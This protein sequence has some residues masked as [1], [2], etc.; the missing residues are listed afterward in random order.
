MHRTIGLTD[1]RAIVSG[2]HSTFGDRSFAAAGPRLW[3]S[4][5]IHLREEDNSYNSFRRELGMFWF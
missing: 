3:N 1:Y 5:P 4:R 2:T